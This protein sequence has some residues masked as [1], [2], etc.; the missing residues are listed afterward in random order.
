M[1]Q[2]CALDFNTA[3]SQLKNT[4]GQYV[5]STCGTAT[6]A[7]GLLTAGYGLNY[8]PISFKESLPAK[9]GSCPKPAVLSA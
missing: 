9:R 7:Y 5:A 8:N 3:Q 2:F 6:Q 1:N 4:A